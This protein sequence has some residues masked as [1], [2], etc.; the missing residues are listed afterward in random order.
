MTNPIRLEKK[1]SRVRGAGYEFVG[2]NDHAAVKICMWTKKSIRGE[3][4]CYKYAFYGIRS[5]RCVQMSPSVPFCNHACIHCWRDTTA[6]F[7]GWEGGEDSPTD[8]A[9][10][11]IK[12]QLHQINGFPGSPKTDM[13]MFREAT[14]PRHVAISLDG[15]PT[16][17]SQLPGLVKEYHRRGMTTFIVSNGTRPEMF[18]RM[19]KEGSLPTQLYISFNSPTRERHGKIVVPLEKDS[20]ENYEKSLKLLAKMSMPEDGHGIGTPHSALLPPSKSKTRT[21]LRMTLALGHNM[22]DIGGYAKQVAIA[23]P[24]FIEVKAYMALGSSRKRLGPS[25]M[26]T[27]AQ[28]REFA[29]ELAKKTGYIMSVEHIPS[30]IV[31]LCRDKECE[32]ERIIDFKKLGCDV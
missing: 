19:E 14:L 8:I 9:D 1:K 15:E 25:R 23:R 24:H 4:V 30:R 3:G 10:G 27:H 5:H 13:K 28:I 31:L 16:L 11:S 20:W 6:H 26:P 32:R 18:A 7:L 22:D 29:K 17:Y 12:A 2:K 21:V